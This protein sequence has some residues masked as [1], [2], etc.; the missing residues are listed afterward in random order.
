MKLGDVASVTISPTQD[1]VRHDA[2]SRTIDVT[3][4]LSGRDADAVASEIKDRLATVQF[5]LEHHAELLRDYAGRQADRRWFI[6]VA[7]AVAIGVFLLLQAA[8][9][10]WRLALVAFVALPAGVS[11]CLVA[12]L[13]TGRTLSLG[14]AV[15]VFGVVCLS[16]RSC[17]TLLHR[18]QSL[19]RHTELSRVDAAQ[20]GT[21]ELVVPVAMTA[22]GV[23]LILLPFVASGTIAG[24]EIVHPMAIAVLGGLVTSTMYNLLVVPALYASGASLSERGDAFLDVI[25]LEPLSTVERTPEPS[26]VQK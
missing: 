12:V 2:V 26:T 5:P 19:E 23:G 10:S 3:A 4:E 8:L 1:V 7:A 9:M 18:F 25:D 13:L 21:R 22:V 24:L 6:A 20:Q 14:A 16:A 17:L 15:G 11:G